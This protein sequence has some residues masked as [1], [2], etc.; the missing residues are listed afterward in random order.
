MFYFVGTLV[1]QGPIDGRF[2]NESPGFSMDTGFKEER[3]GKAPMPA[4]RLRRLDG[5]RLSRNETWNVYCH[6]ERG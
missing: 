6:T 1:A 5:T 3:N 4:K 2:A